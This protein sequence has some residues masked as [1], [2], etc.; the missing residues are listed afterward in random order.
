MSESERKRR[1]S[2]SRQNKAPTIADVAALA[3]VS[4]MTVSRVI[5]SEP[6][7]RAST[8]DTVNAAI[9]RLNYA[10]NRAA[11]SLAGA[12]QLRL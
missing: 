5:N 2:K 12:S 10:P 3:G 9:A 7:V 6:K 8:R 4:I 11:R 1:S